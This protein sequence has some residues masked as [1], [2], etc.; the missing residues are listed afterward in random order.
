[1]KKLRTTT[2]IYPRA[3]TTGKNECTIPAVIINTQNKNTVAI[4]AGTK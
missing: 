2:S 1:M 4:N 3:G